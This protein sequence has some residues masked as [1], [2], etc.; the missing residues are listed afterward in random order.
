VVEQ[1]LEDLSRN[2]TVAEGDLAQKESLH[3]MVKSDPEQTALL[4]Q[5]DLLQRLE[6]KNAD[7]KGQYVDALSQYGPNFP[8]VVRLRDQVTELQSHIDGERKRTVDR[9]QNDYQTALVRKALL[10]NS[11]AQ[12][13]LEV[14]KLNEL[15]IQH[16]MLKREFETNQQLYDSLQQRL[17]D[18]TLS[19][20]L[21]A[22]NIHVV[23]TAMAPA[24]PE[25]PK[26]LFNLS[27]GLVL[28]LLLGISFAFVRE[29][30]EHSS[31]RSAEDVERLVQATCL[32]LIP[33]I[34]STSAARYGLA[35]PGNQKAA[36]NGRVALTVLKDPTSP[37]AESYRALR[38]AILFST[39]PQPPQTLVVT[40]SQP[41][42]GKTSTS[43][44]LAAALSQNGARVLII[45]GDMRNPGLARAMELGNSKGLSGVLTG[46]YG[47]DEALRRVDP[48][49]DLWVLP[50]GPHPPN[51]AE[52][53]SSSAMEAVLEDLRKRF[54]HVVIDSP[55]LLMVTDATI[56]STLVDG[57]VLVVESGVT[58]PGALVRAHRTLV[59][60][61]GRILGVVVNKVDSRQS[62]YYYGY[63]SKYYGSY[64]GTT[65]K[66]HASKE[67]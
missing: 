53:L 25:R 5:N 41:N 4:A 66:E 55:P 30:L 28:G 63:Y 45:D 13:K 12:Q 7:L 3:E 54:E 6:E 21:R 8:K 44:N 24:S 11:V 17:K 33:S 40:S 27:V 48:S 36:K 32:A 49:C 10:A 14:G 19:A 61:G 47:L 52:L 26:K 65:E 2:L 43:L 56:L 58:T 35:K 67:S 15:L 38:S 50:A 57:V 62:G 60:A 64:Y 31:V 1:R 59:T 9:I 18:A 20:G 16:N 37:V 39:A 22:T 29:G 51:P 46:A 42:E 34:N 23:D